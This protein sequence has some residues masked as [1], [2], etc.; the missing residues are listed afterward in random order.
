MTLKKVLTMTATVIMF[1]LIFIIGCSDTVEIVTTPTT[2]N[3]LAYEALEWFPLD[4]GYT[5][6]YKLTSN[7]GSDRIITYTVGKEI[8][9]NDMT[10]VEWL[11][12]DNVLGAD[13]GYFQ[14]TN[15]A[16]YYRESKSSSLEKIIELP[17]IA[18]NSWNRN[19]SDDANL[20]TENFDDQLDGEQEKDSLII[21]PLKNLPIVGEFLMTVEEAEVLQLNETGHYYSQAYR[22]AV[23]SSATEKNYYWF[24]E[25]VGLVKYVLGATELSYPNG[26]VVGELIQYG[27]SE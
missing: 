25:G 26:N 10:V 12:N 20:R 18:G 2:N 8:V 4:E 22:I 7:D 14:Y 17:I 13:T 5:T 15:T 9:I 6:V 11:S 24:V 23:Q 19:E 1:S 21:T 16:I 3:N 27:Y